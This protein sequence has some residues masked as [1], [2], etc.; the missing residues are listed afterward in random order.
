MSI[1]QTPPK[2][3]LG[4]QNK[5]PR[6]PSSSPDIGSQSVSL[7]VAK[8]A[9][10]PS[11]DADTET[12]RKFRLRIGQSVRANI[13]TPRNPEGFRLLH[14]FAQLVSQNI[15]GFEHMPAHQVIKTLQAESGVGCEL[16]SIAA[17]D[18]ASMLPP[19]LQSLLVTPRQTDSREP[20]RMITAFQPRSLAVGKMDDSEFQEIFDG[21]C[22]Y[23][24]LTYWKDMT[25]EQIAE[26][27]RL[28]PDSTP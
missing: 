24:A 10:I 19:D 2:G 14:G 26:T 27:A 5:A 21:L 11:T 4:A 22:R 13:D 18:F 28:M 9:L 25:G 23:I 20:D 6:T 3:K 16:V 17:S 15:E 1:H 8:G 12:L 7:T